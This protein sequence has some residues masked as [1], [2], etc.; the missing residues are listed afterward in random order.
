MSQ[1]RKL[2]C[3]VLVFM[4]LFIGTLFAIDTG[5]QVV[6][7]FEKVEV[8]INGKFV[9]LTEKDE[10]TGQNIFRTPLKTGTYTIKCQ[11]HGY[12][13]WS[14]QI[15]V[16][17]GYIQIKPNFQKVKT[18]AESLNSYT[19]TAKSKVGT[20]K[21]FSNPSGANVR[22]DGE[23]Q[24]VPT[25]C[26][27]KTA[28]GTHKIEVFFPHKK[29][30]SIDPFYLAPENSVKIKVDFYKGKYTIDIAYKI[31]IDSS[32]S[33]A[34]L[35]I[36]GQR[37]GKTPKTLKL[38]YGQHTIKIE[39]K[40]YFHQQR[41]ITVKNND[42][43]TYKLLQPAYIEIQEN[44][45]KK[46]KINDIYIGK[47][48]IKITPI[49]AGN[50]K[51]EI[52]GTSII[53]NIKPYH[54]YKITLDTKWKE[55]ALYKTAEKLPGYKPIPP[56]PSLL[57][58][59]KAADPLLKFGASVLMGG[60]GGLLTTVLTDNEDEKST[61]FWGGTVVF[62]LILFFT[63]PD[64]LPIDKNIEENNKRIAMWKEK[65][66]PIE[67]YNRE[68]LEETNRKIKEYNKRVQNHNKNLLQIQDLGIHKKS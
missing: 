41:T 32:P 55:K 16:S 65:K 54:L 49:P 51:V 23:L 28:A 12:E 35:S 53:Y 45:N 9:G 40:G 66:K 56:G 63:L 38:S 52:D 10:F 37:M 11:Y 24:N 50:T 20:I 17:T 8:F 13:P 2:L 46:V 26:I 33:N 48:P 61:A 44:N 7:K 39:K 19:G 31:T 34:Y 57:P 67:K 6:S 4:S 18:K 27:I 68:L 36:D 3:L 14:K 21:I 60:L 29:V 64:T 59:Y 15:E 30:I 25:D 42:F 58:S 47:T 22:V 43:L 62:T 5:I 1:N